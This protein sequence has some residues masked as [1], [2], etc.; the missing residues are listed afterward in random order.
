MWPGCTVIGMRKVFREIGPD[1]LKKKIRPNRENGPKSLGN[2]AF[3]QALVI[4]ILSS[5]AV[6][7]HPVITRPRVDIF[8]TE[9]LD[10]PAPVKAVNKAVLRETKTSRRG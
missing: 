7:T 9:N 10:E 4:D 5:R 1:K 3:F 2:N 8:V 6:K